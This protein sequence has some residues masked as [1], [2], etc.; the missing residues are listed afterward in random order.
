MDFAPPRFVVLNYLLLPFQY[1]LILNCYEWYVINLL[2]L[3]QKKRSVLEK[4]VLVGHYFSLFF[5]YNPFNLQNL[6]NILI[7][8]HP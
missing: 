8:Y 7:Y 2:L 5:L 1:Y 4:W 6:L 3:V